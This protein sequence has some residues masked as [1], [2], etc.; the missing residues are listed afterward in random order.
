LRYERQRGDDDVVPVSVIRQR[1]CGL[2]M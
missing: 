1:I 2:L